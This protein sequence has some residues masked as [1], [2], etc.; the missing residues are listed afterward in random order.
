MSLAVAAPSERSN[1][2]TIG[3]EEVKK[4]EAN[5]QKIYDVSTPVIS[6]FRESRV[7]I[8]K[9]AYSYFLKEIR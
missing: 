7:L 5:I 6:L 4:R 2:K 1:Y 9:L 3:S 8:Q